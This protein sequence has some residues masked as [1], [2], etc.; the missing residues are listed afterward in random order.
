MTAYL[1]EA[2]SCT[3][4]VLTHEAIS[5]LGPLCIRPL[6]TEGV[7]GIVPF[8]TAILA[9]MD[10]LPE[11]TGF[12]AS[13][14]P[15][16]EHS[17]LVSV[18][19]RMFWRVVRAMFNDSLWQEMP[20][21][22]SLLVVQ[23]NGI[24]LQTEL[25]VLSRLCLAFF[26]CFKSGNLG[27]ALLTRLKAAQEKYDRGFSSLIH[28]GDQWTV[29][30]EFTLLESPQYSGARPC[31]G[32]G[33][34]SGAISTHTPGSGSSSSRLRRLSVDSIRSSLKPPSLP[35]S[36]ATS[37]SMA[38]AC[39]LETPTDIEDTILEDINGLS[40]SDHQPR[41]EG[42]VLAGTSRW[43]RTSTSSCD[44]MDM[45][46]V[47]ADTPK[48]PLHAESPYSNIL[49][50]L[51]EAG[52]HPLIR[53]RHH[54]S[55]LRTSLVTRTVY[56]LQRHHPLWRLRHHPLPCYI[57]DRDRTEGTQDDF[58]NPYTHWAIN[59]LTLSD[60]HTTKD[61]LTARILNRP[62]D[63]H[64]SE[65]FRIAMDAPPYA[66]PSKAELADQ[67][68]MEGSQ[69]LTLVKLTA[70]NSTWEGPIRHRR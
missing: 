26:A 4:R 41:V 29:P 27:S 8:K 47:V 12:V 6:G 56:D 48:R 1:V 35:H 65:T 15:L 37:C 10:S 9:A 64:L 18:R 49:T 24:A 38:Q 30:E 68:A 31:S 59:T 69:G 3:N 14:Q 57:V 20:V 50:V 32:Y 55:A 40:S 19:L 61:G 63:L 2:E 52:L 34:T 53:T 13:V 23:Q 70:P 28:Q 7:R 36:R 33:P 51:S 22:V 11:Y 62:D 25:T 5:A 58:F 39:A 66:A 67:Y 42:T 17:H 45:D 16:D 44:S 21:R 46:E 43:R 54:L 60:A